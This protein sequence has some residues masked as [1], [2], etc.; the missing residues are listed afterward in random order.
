MH[1]NIEI[2]AKSQRHEAIRQVLTDHQAEPKGTDR[3]HDTYFHCTNGRLKLRQGN[4]EK[5]L[6]FYKRS[7]QE[8]PKASHVNLYHPQDDQALRELLIEAHGIWKEV[9]KSR[10]IYFVENVKFHLDTVEGLGTFVE[11][12]AIDK[13]GSIGEEK[14]LEQCTYYMKAFGIGE[15]D[16]L[17]TSY[18]DMVEGNK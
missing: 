7:D 8:G 4:I 14:L 13:D 5:S 6:I 3:Q 10:E 2:K 15:E 1:L 11:I 18:S 17:A 9:I 12:E 16:L